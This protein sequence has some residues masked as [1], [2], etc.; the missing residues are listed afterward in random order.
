MN[1]RIQAPDKVRNLSHKIA[2]YN[3]I[4]LCAYGQFMCAP[5]ETVTSL[6]IVVESYLT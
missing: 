6:L 1:E 2:T 5:W 4:C 3:D